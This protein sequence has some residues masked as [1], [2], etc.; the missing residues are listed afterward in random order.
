[1]ATTATADTRMAVQI[2]GMASG[3]STPRSTCRSDMPVPRPASTVAWST[4]P[5]PVWALVKMGGIASATSATSVGQNPSPSPM[6][7]LTV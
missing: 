2:T 5:T 1:M 6:E 7:R 4:W 3:T